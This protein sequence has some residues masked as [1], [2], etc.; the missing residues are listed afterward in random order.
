[1]EEKG[2]KMNTGSAKANTQTARREPGNTPF[3]CQGV[4]K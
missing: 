3:V 4:Y 2:R 1:M